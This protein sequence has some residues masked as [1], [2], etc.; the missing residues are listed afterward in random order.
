MTVAR[1]TLLGS[2]LIFSSPPLQ[3]K[4][5]GKSKHN[6]EYRIPGT[7]V[8]KTRKIPLVV[9]ND[10]VPE[11]IQEVFTVFLFVYGPFPRPHI[12]Q[13]PTDKSNDQGR[14]QL[15]V[16]FQQEPQYV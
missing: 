7:D 8:I 4:Q 2:H 15:V 10:P 14:D 3:N 13:G 12:T 6:V 11:G 16:P 1:G 5:N 9:F